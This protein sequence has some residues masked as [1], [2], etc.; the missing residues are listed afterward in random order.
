MVRLS[1]VFPIISPIFV[2][3]KILTDMTN[4]LIGR[5]KECTELKRCY[6]SDRSEFIIVY[7]RRRVWKTFLIDQ[8][9]SGHYDFSFV[10]GHKLPRQRQLR[11]FAKA[12]KKYSKSEKESKFTDW[13]EAFDALE[14]YLE[15]L[16]KEQ[17][18]VI[19]IDEMPWRDTIKSDFVD[20]L[21]NFWNSW[22]KIL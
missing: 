9:F 3:E 7:G 14:E 11:N 5:G 6:D 10:G 18:K 4:K 8:Y 22:K 21:E 1:Y 12:L 15:S 19:F 16:S 2:L 20:A 13:F 17:K